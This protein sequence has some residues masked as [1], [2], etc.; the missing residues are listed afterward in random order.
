MS[1]DL[2]S[3]CPDAIRRV[4]KVQADYMKVLRSNASDGQQLGKST[5][6]CKLQVSLLIWLRNHRQVPGRP[7][8]GS[9]EGHQRIYTFASIATRKQ[10]ESHLWFDCPLYTAISKQNKSLFE[11]DQGSIR[12]DRRLKWNEM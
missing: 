9:H 4:R 10:D 12:P 5:A 6:P 1:L 7:N 11:H 2:A 3:G 8:F